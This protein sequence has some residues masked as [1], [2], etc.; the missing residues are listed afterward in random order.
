MGKPLQ[1]LMRMPHSELRTAGHDRKYIK[2]I[3]IKFEMYI[4]RQ[5]HF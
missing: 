1:L 5:T 2:L 3:H 4:S